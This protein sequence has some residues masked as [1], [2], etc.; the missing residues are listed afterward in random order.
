M[1]GPFVL[2]I[3]IALS[4]T[5]AAQG[6]QNQYGGGRYEEGVAVAVTGS[7]ITV[8]VRHHR[9]GSGHLLRIL[10]TSLTG[11]APVFSDIT[12]PGAVFPQGAAPAA[13]GG[14]VVCGSLIPNGRNDQDALLLKLDP[15]GAVAWTW[16]SNNASASEELL[17]VQLMQDG[18]VLACGTRRGNADADALLLQLSPTGQLQWSQTYGD[19]LDQRLHALVE[20]GQGIVAVGSTS[21]F[22]GDS[23]AYV[24][25]TEMEG[26]EQWWQTWGGIRD[27]EAMDVVLRPDGS[28][29]WAG[30]TD[31]L[32]G[33]IADANGMQHRQVYTMAL[34]A[35]GDTLWTRVLGDTLMDHAAFALVN[36]GG[37]DV[38]L[39]GERG[40]VGRSDAV[41]HRMTL[42]GTPLWRRTYGIL[43]EDRLG[44]IAMM[45]DGGFV[46][47]GRGFGALGGQVIL[48]RKNSS[49]L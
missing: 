4:A 47:T 23:D 40:A 35:S 8:A 9:E 19:G 28:F 3:C 26:T 31:E 41:V 45:P 36:T 30:Y 33:G 20:D 16:T 13:D 2:L 44:S 37:G 18:R 39:A 22:S 34:T 14:L 27:D 5:L 7:N 42:M 43:R 29:Q 46:S 38:L 11:N 17:D 49:G 6:F 15:F 10:R 12:L 32:P 48:L 25:R 1:R 21:T 24:L